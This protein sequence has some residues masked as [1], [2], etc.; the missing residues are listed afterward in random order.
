MVLEGVLGR[1]LEGVLE[2]VLGGMSGGVL[3]GVFNILELICLPDQ[4]CIIIN[5]LVVL[6]V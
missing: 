2:G 6:I 3:E 4:G 5:I 1:V